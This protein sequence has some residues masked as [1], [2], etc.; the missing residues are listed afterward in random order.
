MDGEP[1]RFEGKKED[2]LSPRQSNLT[3]QLQTDYDRSYDHMGMDISNP[4]D[5][6]SQ[7]SVSMSGMTPTQYSGVAMPISTGKS[8]PRRESIAGSM[9]HGVSFGGVSMGSWVHD[10]CVHFFA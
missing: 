1:A 9:M 5:R 4:S 6:Y 8:N 7:N 3:A 2:S 10:E